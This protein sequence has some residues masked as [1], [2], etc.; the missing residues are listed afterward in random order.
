MFID[1]DLTK[2]PQRP[3]LYLCK[4]NK[5]IIASLNEFYGVNL[6]LNLTTMNELIFDLPYQIDINHQLQHNIHCDLIK[7]RFL[8]KLILG[9]YIEFFIIDNPSPNGDDNTD[10]LQI[11]CYSLEYELKN[12]SIRKYTVNAVLLSEVMN[13]FSRDV[14]TITNGISSTVITST[15]GILKE[16][17]WILGEFPDYCN[18]MYRSFDV[19]VKTKLDFILEIAEKFNLVA[20]F[21]S[22]LR[23]INFYTIDEIGI[24]KGLRISNKRYLRTIVQNI[25]SETFCTRLKLYGKDGLTINE[26]NPTGQNYIENYSN[27]LFPF[28]RNAETR[29]VITRSDY[30]S[31]ELCHAILDYQILLSQHKADFP[32]LL[33]ILTTKQTEMTILTNAMTILTDAMKLINDNLATA[34]GSKKTI[35]TT[36]QINKQIEIDAQQLLINAKQIE[37]DTA[38]DNIKQIATDMS[39]EIYFTSELLEELILYI[40]E[41]DWTN[42]SLMTAEDLYIYGLDEMEKR[43][44]PVTIIQI[45]IVNF[46]EILNEQSNWDK[47]NIGD[48]ISIKH[49]QL[50]IDLTARII[51]CNFDFE[52]AEIQLTISN[53]KSKNSKLEDILYNTTSVV[54]IIDVNRL[55]WDSSQVNATEYVD[56]QIQEMSGT[57]LN[58][59]IDIARFGDDLYITKDEAN[60]LKL[61]LEQVI[62]E[63]LNVLEISENLEITTERYDYSNALN[64]L[65]TYLIAEWIG[66]TDPPLTYPIAIISDASPYDERIK[67]TELF[68]DVQNAKSILINKISS[69]RQT[70]AINYIKS[71]VTELDTVLREF[72]TA[73]NGYIDNT[74][75]EQ[76]ESIILDEI[77]TRVQTESNDV[78]GLVT[79]LRPLII[80]ADLSKLNTV[81]NDYTDALDAAFNSINDWIGKTTYPILIPVSKG[82]SV[83]DKLKKVE[84]TKTILNATIIKIR[85]DN[86]LTVIDEQIFE[87]NVAIAAMQSDIKV[88]AENYEFAI[89]FNSIL[90]T[91]IF[92]HAISNTPTSL[93]S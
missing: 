29:E 58:L 2:T 84:S 67:I 89:F 43:K 57:L 90:S 65:Q 52:S 38:N 54:D 91:I 12:K 63:S 66:P 92:S 5:T 86:Q 35:Y 36:Q 72:Q 74:K 37:I 75:I 46:L 30:M 78:T 17:G 87:A 70:D 6:K 3:K 24:N 93:Y 82:L 76:S 61:T 49:E 31:D 28:Q 21:D 79:N 41:K 47:I 71:E 44:N 68:E 23:K 10:F 83:K 48:S 13:G 7:N 53:V 62:A 88:F 32:T 25:D 50:G 15:D 39:Y 60:T 73:I 27:F 22:N 55:R 42:E 77:R 51:E 4:P 8:I 19:S 81:E 20:K 33:G 16:T 69:V 11:N 9:E 34:S 45:N 59:N 80:G 56:Q 85:E 40:Y 1:I 14:T 26:I 18:S 64:A